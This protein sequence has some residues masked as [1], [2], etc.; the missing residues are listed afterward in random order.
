MPNTTQAEPQWYRLELLTNSAEPAAALLWSGGAQGV[1]IQDLETFMEGGTMAPVPDGKTRLIAFFEHNEDSVP[2]DDTRALET[3][4]TAGV[5]PELVSYAAFTDRSWETAWMDFFK[6]LALSR[7]VIVGPPWESFEAPVGGQRLVI[8]PG[9]AFGT[10]THETTQLC[11]QILDDLLDG[12]QELSVIDVGCG[13]AI[14]AMAAARLGA[15]P[16]VGVDNDPTAVEVA[17]A[18]LVVNDLQ[19]RIV[20]STTPIEEVEGVFDIVVANILPHVLLELREAL[21][22]HVAPEAGTL[23]LS[24]ITEDKADEVIAGFVQPGWRLVQRRQAAEWVA[25]E[26]ERTD[27]R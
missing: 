2:A 24:G 11:A 9:M 3:L 18:N 19:D 7:R 26:V 12:D 5:E 10:G 6:P 14:L 22:A 17:L 4:A 27:A 25:L 23:I 21:I 20:L 16:V 15:H 13:S 8:E 1:E